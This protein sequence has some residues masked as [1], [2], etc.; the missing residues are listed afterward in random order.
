MVRGP[1]P[2]PDR[3]QVRDMRL[4]IRLSQVEYDYLRKLAVKPVRSMGEL[5]RSLALAGMPLPKE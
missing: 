1:K 4:T 5:V 2:N 3:K